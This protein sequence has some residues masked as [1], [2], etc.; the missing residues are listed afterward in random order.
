M[1]YTNP[2]RRRITNFVTWNDWVDLDG[3]VVDTS[4]FE[5]ASI[6]DDVAVVEE[7]CFAH[8]GGCGGGDA[9][10]VE[11]TAEEEDPY[12]RCLLSSED[13]CCSPSCFSSLTMDES[14]PPCCRCRRRCNAIFSCVWSV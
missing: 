12:L 2:T 9:F 13:G 6:N 10:I 11:T 3:G 4:C 14:G 7:V 8:C 1:R 5:A